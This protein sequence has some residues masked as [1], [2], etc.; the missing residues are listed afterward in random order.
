MRAKVG[1]LKCEGRG[2]MLCW[3]SLGVR[4]E[5]ETLR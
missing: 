4:A 2:R 1:R 5:V 3:E